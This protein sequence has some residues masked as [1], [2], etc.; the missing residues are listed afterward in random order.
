M[1]YIAWMVGGTLLTLPFGYLIEVKADR[2]HY[3]FWEWLN[4]GCMYPV[5]GAPADQFGTSVAW[6]AGG[7]VL[8][9]CAAVLTD[10]GES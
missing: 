6:A 9:I 5:D 4:Y 7:L 8:G 10:R 2:F 1:R 3:S